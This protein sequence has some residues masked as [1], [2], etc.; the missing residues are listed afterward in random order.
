MRGLCHRIPPVGASIGRSL[1]ASTQGAS[2]PRNGG[3]WRPDK[4]TACATAAQWQHR[5]RALPSGPTDPGAPSAAAIVG[6]A[7]PTTTEGV[8]RMVN[9]V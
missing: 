4:A 7:P 5:L 9:G 6:E 2:M 3:G 8:G 1:A